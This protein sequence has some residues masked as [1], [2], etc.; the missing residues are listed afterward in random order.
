MMNQSQVQLT[1]YQILRQDNQV[2][3]NIEPFQENQSNQIQQQKMPGLQTCFDEINPQIVRKVLQQNVQYQFNQINENRLDTS[4]DQIL[5]EINQNNEN[6]ENYENDTQNVQ[7]ESIQEQHQLSENDV[8]TIIQEV[9]RINNEI[10][11]SPQ[12]Y[13]E[14]LNQCTNMGQRLEE[15]QDDSI[16]KGLD[17]KDIDL[18]PIKKYKAQQDSNQDNCSKVKQFQQKYT[19]I[20]KSKSKNFMFSS[21]INYY[22]KNQK[23]QQQKKNDMISSTSSIG[24]SPLMQKAQSE[25]VNVQKLSFDNVLTEQ[26]QPMSLNSSQ[27]LSQPT[28]QVRTQSFNEIQSQQQSDIPQQVNKKNIWSIFRS[29]NY[30]T[31]TKINNNKNE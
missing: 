27:T 23:L 2:V 1:Q 30:K 29:S 28:K 18:I 21:P 11:S 8:L 24:E 3:V 19:E 26:Q 16:P 13:Q 6:Q 20:E 25:Q 31:E 5:Y 12:Q 15:D 4:L 22:A 7:N 10:K 9:K 17:Q 14:I